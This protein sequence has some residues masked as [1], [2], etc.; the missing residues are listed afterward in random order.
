MIDSIIMW[1]CLGFGSI[2][3]IATTEVIQKMEVT[4]AS[5]VSVQ[6]HNYKSSQKDW[7]KMCFGIV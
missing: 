7:K 4:N 3:I 6:R 1:L 2:I 5:G